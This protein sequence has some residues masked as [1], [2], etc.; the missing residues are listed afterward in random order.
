MQGRDGGKRSPAIV[1]VKGLSG[2][3]KHVIY[4]LLYF[5]SVDCQKVYI[6]FG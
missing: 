2:N 5:V 4:G 1:G 3:T 6:C